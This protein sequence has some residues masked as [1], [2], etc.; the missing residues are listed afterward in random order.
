LE[1][2]RRGFRN[3]SGSPPGTPGR[4]G[5]G[6]GRRFSSRAGDNDGRREAE[7]RSAER[8]AS[9]I[10]WAHETFPGLEEGWYA[11]IASAAM[12]VKR[13]G[14]PVNRENVI[15]RVRATYGDEF[16]DEH[17]LPRD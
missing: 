13:S 4:E 11:Q 14:K 3:P 9:T 12:M 1:S 6:S 10:G 16:A 5:I 7:A 17:G 2:D 15:E 8:I